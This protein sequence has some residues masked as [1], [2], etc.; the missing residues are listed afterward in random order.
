M[1]P[2]TTAGEEMPAW[3]ERR[4]DVFEYVARV[5][6]EEHLGLAVSAALS[7]RLSGAKATPDAIRQRLRQSGR[8]ADQLRAKGWL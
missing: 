5:L 4:R 7:L 8:S 6:P 2:N 3:S 1:A